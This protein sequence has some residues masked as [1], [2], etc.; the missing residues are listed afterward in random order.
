MPRYVIFSMGVV[1]GVN[2]FSGG[3]IYTSKMRNFRVGAG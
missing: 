1:G 3:S 2:Y